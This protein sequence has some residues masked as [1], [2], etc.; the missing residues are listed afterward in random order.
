MQGAFGFISFL[1]VECI[2]ECFDVNQPVGFPLLIFLRIYLT[3]G[4]SGDV[5]K[6]GRRALFS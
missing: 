5:W 4:C 3:E 1:G 6:Q 2:K